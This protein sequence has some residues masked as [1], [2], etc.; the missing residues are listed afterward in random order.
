MYVYTS[1]IE[2]LYDTKYCKNTK[3]KQNFK[4]AQCNSFI[5]FPSEQYFFIYREYENMTGLKIFSIYLMVN[6]LMNTTSINAST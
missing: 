4:L 5:S 2:I 1:Q 6:S 3:L